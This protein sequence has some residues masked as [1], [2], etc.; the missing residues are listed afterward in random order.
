[1]LGLVCIKQKIDDTLAGSVLFPQLWLL[2][3]LDQ[4]AS[5]D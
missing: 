1:M 3:C 2:G 4:Q 5:P